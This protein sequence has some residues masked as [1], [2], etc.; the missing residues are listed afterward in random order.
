MTLKLYLHIRLCRQK[1]LP[2]TVNIDV[3]M[4]LPFKFQTSLEDKG[5]FCTR[6]FHNF[7]IGAIHST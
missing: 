2:E 1:L 5:I 3:F 4:N 7:N 6:F